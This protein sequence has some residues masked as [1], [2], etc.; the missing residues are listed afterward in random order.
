LLTLVLE[1]KKVKPMIRAV[2][3]YPLFMF[4]MMCIALAALVH[5]KTEW[6]PIEHKS[7]NTIEDMN[8]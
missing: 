6:V 3:L 8:T 7:K 5:P 2:L 4:S 1:H